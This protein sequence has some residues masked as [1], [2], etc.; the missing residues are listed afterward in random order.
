MTKVMNNIISKSKVGAV[1]LGITLA[2]GLTSCN[3]LFEPAIE[4]HLGFEYMYD[5]PDY[6]DGV[7]GNVGLVPLRT[8]VVCGELPAAFHVTV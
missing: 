1:V 7:L 5:H 3:D 8:D 2:M 4:N 6:A